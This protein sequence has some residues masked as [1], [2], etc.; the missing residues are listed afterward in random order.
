[1]AAEII[2][3]KP[4][5]DQIREEIKKETERLKTKGVNPKLSVVLVGDDPASV[6]YARSKEKVGDKLGVQV[7]LTVLSGDTPE[8]DV[9]D[10]IK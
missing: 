4:V 3:G 10:L 9:I 6:V 7:D 2:K 1:M 8:K 5:A